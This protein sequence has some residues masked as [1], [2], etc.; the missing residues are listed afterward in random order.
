M[1]TFLVAILMLIGITA[2]GAT[3]RTI[4]GLPLKVVPD[5]SD[6]L[7]IDDGVNNWHVTVDS[8]RGG[9]PQT[10]PDNVYITSNYVY[11]SYITNLYVNIAFITNLTVVNEFH[12]KVSY[13]TNL[14]VNNSF[15]TN[16]VTYN[17]T[18]SNG[19]FTNVYTEFHT[20]NY[21]FVTNLFATNAYVNFFTNNYAFIT[22]LFATNVYLNFVTNNY[23]FSTNLFAT[24]VYINFL[25]NNYLF[26]TN[27]Y[28]T[29]TLLNYITN[30]YL[31]TTNVTA[32]GIVFP[33]YAW[34]GPTN[35]LVCGGTN[36]WKYTANSDCAITQLVAYASGF[37][38][39]A[40]LAITNSAATNITVRWSAPIRIPYGYT[41][42]AYVVTNSDVIMFSADV[43][44]Y[45]SNV[46]PRG[47]GP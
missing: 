8:I 22:N 4:H 45:G 24:N 20:N 28:A 13:I 41:S 40:V 33:E 46:V 31:L 27:L 34:D 32:T 42:R 9:T 7:P 37:A 47:F 16:L 29:N 11:Q 21:L 26:T 15:I 6:M 14:Y 43:A 17:I 23:L 39:S 18:G 35:L 2:W 19:Y 1:K 30:T 5:S 3:D 38:N 25:T 10:A 44:I 12:G 36:R